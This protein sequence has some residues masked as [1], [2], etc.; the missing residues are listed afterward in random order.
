MA[1]ALTGNDTWPA[2]AT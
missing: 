2:L 1:G